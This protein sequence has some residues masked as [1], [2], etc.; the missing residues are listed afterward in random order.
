MRIILAF[1]LQKY[2]WVE[3]GKEILFAEQALFLNH[4]KVAL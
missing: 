3:E 4:V 2:N 1:Y